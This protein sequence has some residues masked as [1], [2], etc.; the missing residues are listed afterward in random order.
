[1]SFKVDK[2]NNG[3]IVYISGEIDL[4]I[5]G[6]MKDIILEQINLNQKEHSFNLSKSVYANL[7]EVT[8]IDSSGIAGLIQSHQQAAKKGVNF[9]L[10][11]VSISVLKVI[12]LARLDKI[13]K[14]KEEISE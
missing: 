5:S 7:S 1:M 8:Y 6:E 12:K 3:S 2:I 9:Y 13:F 4:S 10:F 11:K 14:I